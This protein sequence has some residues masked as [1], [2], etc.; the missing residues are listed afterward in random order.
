MLSMVVGICEKRYF[1]STFNFNASGKALNNVR[2]DID[3]T[4]NMAEI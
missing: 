3:I 1:F 2:S 4:K